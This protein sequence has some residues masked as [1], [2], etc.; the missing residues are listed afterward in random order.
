MMSGTAP[1]HCKDC[2][3]PP[4]PGGRRCQACRLAHN[5]RAAMARR[6][7][8]AAGK[9]WVCGKPGARVDGVRL[10]TCPNHREYFRIRAAEADLK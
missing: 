2:A 10:G 5:A 4:I 1:T 7:R 9:C 8:A 3:Q 6:M